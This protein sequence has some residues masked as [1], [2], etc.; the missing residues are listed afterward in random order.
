MLLLSFHY[1]CDYTVPKVKNPRIGLS[2]CYIERHKGLRGIAA[3][4]VQFN[5]ANF[6]ISRF[7][8]KLLEKVVLIRNWHRLSQ[9][10]R[11]STFSDKV[12][13]ISL[14]ISAERISL[15]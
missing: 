1:F 15:M 11:I 12:K 10:S 5:S 4:T 3:S 7:I 2:R 8:V 14:T 13:S 6:F 9:V